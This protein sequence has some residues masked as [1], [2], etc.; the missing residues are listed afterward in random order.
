MFHDLSVPGRHGLAD[1][2]SVSARL[3]ITFGMMI[4][5]LVVGSVLGLTSLSGPHHKLE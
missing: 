5:M 4:C 1:R 2:L 3:T